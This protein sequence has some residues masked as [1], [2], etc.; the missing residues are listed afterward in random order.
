MSSDWQIVTQLHDKLGENALWHPIERAV[1]WIDWYGAIIHR[2]TP[3]RDAVET[4]KV[5]G[6]ESVGAAVFA[7]DGRLLL[8]SDKGVVLFDPASQALTPFADPLKG[9]TGIGFNDGKVDHAGRL[10]IGTFEATEKEPRAAFHRIDGKG[11]SAIGDGGFIVCNGPAFSPDNRVLYF[12]DTMGRKIL[13]YDIDAK[14]GALSGKR[15]F[16]TLG[17]NDGLP[18]G[19]TVDSAG[20]LWCAHYGVGKLSRFTPD[21]KRAEEIALPVPVVT[22][23]C[24]G[25]DD[26]KTLYVTTGWTD[27]AATSINR[28]D[29]GGALYARQVATPGLPEPIFSPEGTS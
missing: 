12:S 23:C 7:R 5:P 9:E 19:L 3:A 18:D 27:Q 29:K 22:S 17:D 11:K 21:G 8:G 10:W 16:A 26:L 4:W 25:G 28:A 1:Y 15:V 20:D 24:F 6:L 14:T 13:A 2:Y